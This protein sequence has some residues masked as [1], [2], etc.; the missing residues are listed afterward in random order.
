MYEP[1]FEPIALIED[2]CHAIYEAEHDAER[3]TY[4]VHGPLMPPRTPNS[5]RRLPQLRL[6]YRAFAATPTEAF[7]QLTQ[8]MKVNRFRMRQRLIA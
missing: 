8:W 6:V 7:L 3:G 4:E 1:P 2:E 5:A